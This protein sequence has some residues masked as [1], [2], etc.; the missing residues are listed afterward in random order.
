MSVCLHSYLSYLERKAHFFCPVLF[1]HM[2]P[3]CPYRIFPHYL[4]K[5]RYPEKK[6]LNT[7]C[8]FC[9]PLQGLSATFLILRRL[10]CVWS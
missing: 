5:V 9:F 7:K 3:V 2:W 8:V 6:L 1:G 10:Q 4:K